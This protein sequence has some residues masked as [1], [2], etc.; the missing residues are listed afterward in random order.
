MHVLALADGCHDIVHSRN[1]REQQAHVQEQHKVR[2]FLPDHPTG[3]S[4]THGHLARVIRTARALPN[5][6]SLFVREP[7]Q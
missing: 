5:L 4:H 1:D 6:A 3:Q 2:V 7:V